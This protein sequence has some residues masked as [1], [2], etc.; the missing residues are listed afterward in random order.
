M[1]FLIDM[2]LSPE[3]ADW[4][5]ANGHDAI[6]A[7]LVALSEASDL[8]IVQRAVAEQRTIITADLDFTRLFAVLESE[9]HGLV[10]FRGGDYTET[11]CI[12][13]LNRALK[14]LPASAFSDSVIV[15]EKHRI[16]R[17]PLPIRIGD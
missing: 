12:E 5:S 13:R 6:H 10:L 1:I 8:E 7:S 15:I 9:G 3:L 4:L 17:R 2:P 14:V 11:E 16:R